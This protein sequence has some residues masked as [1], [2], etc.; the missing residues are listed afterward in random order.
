MSFL[1]EKLKSRLSKK[2]L[3]K[4]PSSFEVIGDI[5]ILETRDLKG[6]DR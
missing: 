1:K 5:A 2:D 6:K 4:V 3:E